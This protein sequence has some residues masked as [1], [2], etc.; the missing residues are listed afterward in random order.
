MGKI[1]ANPSLQ[2][3]DLV[4]R[5]FDSSDPL[6][7]L[8]LF[9]DIGPELPGGFQRCQGVDIS[10]GIE[11]FRQVGKGFLLEEVDKGHFP[12]CLFAPAPLLL[13]A[14]C[15]AYR[16]AWAGDHGDPGV[17]DECLVWFGVGEGTHFIAVIV[18]INFYGRV[19]GD[20]EILP[21]YILVLVLDGVKDDLVG[22]VTDRAFIRVLSDMMDAETG[23]FFL[24]Y[25][26]A[27]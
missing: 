9:K 24:G 1:L 12:S 19:A 23:H 3:P 26:Y 18:L 20:R 21:H 7:I 5:G 2:F 14:G 15:I 13:P 17:D 27:K 22:T 4:E 6:D 8:E 11:H 25:E 16:R 10:Q